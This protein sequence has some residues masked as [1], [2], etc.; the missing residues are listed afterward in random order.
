M[1]D[2]ALPGRLG[3]Q[4]LAE[5]S[6]LLAAWGRG[7]LSLLSSIGK[8]HRCRG[9]MRAASC[10]VAAASGALLLDTGFTVTLLSL[11][12]EITEAPIKALRH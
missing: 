4:S 12:E 10:W 5:R 8:D 11:E 6:A 3:F 2:R 7:E 1:V 9:P